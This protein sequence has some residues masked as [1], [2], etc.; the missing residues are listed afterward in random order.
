MPLG[1]ANQA[2]SQPAGLIIIGRV[3]AAWQLSETWPEFNAKARATI[4]I[5]INSVVVR[6]T[7]SDI[8]NVASPIIGWRIVCASKRQ[9]QTTQADDDG[10]ATVGRK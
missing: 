10:G 8:F 2:N 3:G 1:L 9:Q 4:I 5:I 7:S 6:L